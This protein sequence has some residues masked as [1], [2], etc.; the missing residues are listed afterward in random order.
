[1]DGA[2]QTDADGRGRLQDTETVV[3]FGDI[4]A[5]ITNSIH[6]VET[7][8]LAIIEIIASTAGVQHAYTGVSTTLQTIG[9]IGIA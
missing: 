9:K 6:I 1:M 7:I 5:Y 2:S 3:V 8:N 4:I